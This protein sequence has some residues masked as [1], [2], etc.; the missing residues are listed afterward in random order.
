MPSLCGHRISGSRA[1]DTAWSENL[2]ST[3]QPMFGQGTAGA[4]ANGLAGAESP[5]YGIDALSAARAF[6]TDILPD[7]LRRRERRT[8]FCAPDFDRAR[9]VRATL[10]YPWHDIRIADAGGHWRNISSV[11]R[12]GEQMGEVVQF[13]PRSG[14]SQE[15]A[16]LIREARAIY[17]A[18]FPTETANV[19]PSGDDDT[20]P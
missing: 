18:I 12:L 20:S 3:L 8:R 4:A 10:W 1:A 7:E 19:T 17:E 5:S 15:A 9:R 14:S 11:S 13:I 6:R 2:S 16:R